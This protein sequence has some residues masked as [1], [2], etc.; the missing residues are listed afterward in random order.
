VLLCGWHEVCE[1]VTLHE[2][3]GLITV[4]VAVQVDVLPLASVTVRVTWLAPAFDTVN[5]VF[6]AVVETIPQLSV[7]PPSICAAVIVAT[8][9][10]RVTV[11]LLHTATGLMVSLIVTVARQLSLRPASSVTVKVTGVWPMLEQLNDVLET[12]RVTIVQLSV[13]P[14]STC[15]AVKVAVPCALR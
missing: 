1:A 9:L 8:P 2:I 3:E 11:M 6:E 15:A 4:T 10:T 7:L 13:L 5:V 14:P 12:V